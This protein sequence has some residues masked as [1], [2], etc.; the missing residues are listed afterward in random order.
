MDQGQ[1][2][3]FEDVLS[4]PASASSTWASQAPAVG[5]VEDDLT[6]PGQAR[7]AA[8]SSA[9]VRPASWIISSW[10]SNQMPW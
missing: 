3:A 7:P 5:G 2:V 10:S 6:E 4:T 9:R 8:A 1:S